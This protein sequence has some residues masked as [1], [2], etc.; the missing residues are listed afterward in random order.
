MR[1]RRKTLPTTELQETTVSGGEDAYAAADARAFLIGRLRALPIEYR[2]AVVLRD[3]EGLSNEEVARV[4][5]IS[6]AAAKSRVHRGRM[7]L[8]A[9]LEQWERPQ[10]DG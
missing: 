9:E 2:T 6:L 1:R 5:E 4:L 7:Q 10:T 3:I 8:R